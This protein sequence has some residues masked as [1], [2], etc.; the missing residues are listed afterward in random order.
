MLGEPTRLSPPNSDLI[1]VMLPH[2]LYGTVS[3]KTRLGGKRHTPLLVL[4]VR[5]FRLLC[6]ERPKG[7][8][9]RH[10]TAFGISRVTNRS[11]IATNLDEHVHKRCRWWYI[12][13]PVHQQWL[14]DCSKMFPSTNGVRV[15]TSYRGCDGQVTVRLARITCEYLS[16]DR[17]SGRCL[18]AVVR[19][20][21]NG[22]CLNRSSAEHTKEH[23]RFCF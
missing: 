12:E 10:D 5:P 6:F 14:V 22:G 20:S 13:I 15:G 3:T 19:S 16:E 23:Q 11:Y 17:S 9:W 21:S 4:L 1:F 18:G 7:P 2:T 8:L